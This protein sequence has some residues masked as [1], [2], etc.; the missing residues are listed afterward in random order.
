L[1]LGWT[2]VSIKVFFFFFF[3]IECKCG[4]WGGLPD[5]LFLYPKSQLG[6]ILDGIG[7]IGMKIVGIFYDNFKYFTAI[8]YILRPFGICSV[9]IW[10]IISLFG[11]FGTRK[12][13]AAL[14]PAERIWKSFADAAVEL[15]S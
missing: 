10:Y 4:N 6:Y 12:N 2:S 8:L 14:H 11:M 7:G 1:F 9:I 13:L 15:D 3:S 5:G